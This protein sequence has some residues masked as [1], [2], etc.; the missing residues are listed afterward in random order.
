MTI[1]PLQRYNQPDLSDFVVHFVK[2]I[3]KSSSAVPD[4]I[5]AKTAQERFEAILA[6][7]QILAFPPFGYDVGVPVV[8][9]TECTPAGI[10]TLLSQTRYRPLAIAFEKDFLFQNGGGPAFYIRGDE[11]EFVKDLP[12]QLRGRATRLWPGRDGA[13]DKWQLEDP[14]LDTRS[15]WTHEREWRVHGTGSPPAFNFSL[16]D[17]AF[18]IVPTKEFVVSI[19][20]SLTINHGVTPLDISKIID[21]PCVYQEQG[22]FVDEQGVWLPSSY[23]RR[24]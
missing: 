7:K 19:V 10:G 5:H 21:L 1:R 16:A 23:R 2:R 6:K 24:A 11:W 20:A 9:F 15:E 14:F 13:V 17:I 3:G 18:F 4:D 8:C 12:E 22:E